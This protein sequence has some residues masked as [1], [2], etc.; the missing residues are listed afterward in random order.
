MKIQ[1]R[2]ITVGILLIIVSQH[3]MSVMVQG[4]VIQPTPSVSATDKIERGGA[5]DSINIRKRLI[6][7][8]GHEYALTA[9]PVKV[10]TSS[11]G[12]DNENIL[13]SG[14]KIRFNTSKHNYSA[15]E[16]VFEIWVISGSSAP[17]GR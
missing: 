7:I 9:R 15:Q 14:M 16:Q 12:L 5:I 2:L 8:D 4:E 3:A 17:L 11:G 13:G 10:H 1:F 6:S